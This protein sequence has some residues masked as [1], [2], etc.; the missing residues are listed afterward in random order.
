MTSGGRVEP[1]PRGEWAAD[2]NV[3]ESPL[4]WSGGPWGHGSDSDQTSVFPAVVDIRG[5]RNRK[6]RGI[7]CRASWLAR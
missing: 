4:G 5:A 7:D 3:R 1:Q 6:G 2:T